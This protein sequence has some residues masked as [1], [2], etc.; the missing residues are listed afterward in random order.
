MPDIDD[1][2]NPGEIFI[3]TPGRIVAVE[4]DSR[5]F[6]IQL[7]NGGSARASHEEPVAV[8]A[9][10]AVLVSEQ[11]W[12]V[13]PPAALA[14]DSSVGVVRKISDESIVLES[15]AGIQLIPNDPHGDL[16]LSPGNTVEFDVNTGVRRIV[17]ESPIR[18]RDIGVDDDVL[19]S[20]LIDTSGDTGL[21]FESFGGYEEVAARAKELIETQL[22]RS[23]ELQE[24][25]AKP[26]KG[27]IFT[28][29]PGTGKTHLARIIA[30]VSG[31]T[32]YLVS[33]PSIVSKFVGDSEET[34]R[35]LFDEAARQERAIIFFDEIDS[36]AA[37]RTSDSNGE[38][39]RVVAQLLTLLDGFEPS[40]NVVVIA[41]TNRVEDIDEALLR[42][43]R[44]DWEIQFGMPTAADRY[45]ILQ[46]N[47]SQLKTVD[48]LPLE[49]LATLTE[50]WSGAMLTAIWTEAALLAANAGR[51]AIGDEDLAVAYERVQNRPIHG[52]AEASYVA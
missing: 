45:K 34:L 39:K 19:G 1:P 30:H 22:D 5:T 50:G 26:V 43:G 42:P 9:G 2:E 23:S 40:S 20:Y 12:R 3:G 18:L 36:I 48:P 13:I 32:F 25:G 49:E 51:K 38:S 29:P 35:R 41:A 52:R 31:A 10:T 16:K 28:G 14:R 46:V 4:D 15:N 8:A 47:A 24:I 33:G 27:V 11:G 37:R 44:F 21:T 17:S 6:H 7:R